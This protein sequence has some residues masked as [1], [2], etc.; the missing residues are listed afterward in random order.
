MKNLLRKYGTEHYVWKK[1][2][3]RGGVFY[4]ADADNNDCNVLLNN[5]VAI[6]KDSRKGKVICKSCGALIKNTPEAI[7]KHYADMESKKDCLKCQ[8]LKVGAHNKEIKQSYVLQEDG[9]Y[10]VTSKFNAFLYCGKG[11]YYYTRYPINSLA[12]HE[13][14][15][16]FECRHKGVT[17]PSDIFLKYPGVFD[18]MIT[19]DALTAHKWKYEG[20]YAENFVFDGRSRGTLKA[21]VNSIGIVDKFELRYRGRKYYFYYSYKYDKLFRGDYGT[22]MPYEIPQ[23]KIADAKKKI[24]ALYE[25][26]TK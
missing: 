25:E 15:M 7:E 4:V 13:S 16:Y 1:A 18:D 5:I 20:V 3:W 12:A 19:T 6:D 11:S 17:E 24:R 22:M 14:C 9:T 26:V 2:S 23:S 10:N 8:H 21:H